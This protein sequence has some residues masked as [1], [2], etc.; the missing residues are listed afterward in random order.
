MTCVCYHPLIDLQQNNGGS[1]AL[2]FFCAFIQ[3]SSLV[4]RQ[5][6]PTGCSHAPATSLV[7]AAVSHVPR[8]T[9]AAH[10]P[11][12]SPVAIGC[13]V[14]RAAQV[15]ASPFCLCAPAFSANICVLIYM[16]IVLCAVVWDA[17]WCLTCIVL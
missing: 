3:M 6:E 17:F 10:Q 9:V 12:A 11:C 16:R 13:I 14:A 7:A 1:I 4:V 15:N 5:A 2:A 8:D